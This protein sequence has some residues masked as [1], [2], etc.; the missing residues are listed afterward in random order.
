MSTDDNPTERLQ[1]VPQRS[2]SARDEEVDVSDRPFAVDVER[3]Q[4]LGTLGKGGMGE[5]L[6]AKDTR[7]ARKVAIKVLQPHLRE[8]RDFRS[9]FLIEAR[10]QGQLE[11][12]SIV[13]VHDLGEREDGEL[14]FSM[15]CVRGVTLHEALK[16]VRHGQQTT[17]FSRRR[18]LTAFSSVCL[19]IDFAHSRGVVHRDLKPAN[20]ML[21]DFGEVYV[22]DWGIAKLISSPDT[23]IEHAL[24]IP[25]SGDAATR[26]DKVLGTPHYMAPEQK[27]G[28][29]S[30]A[31]D[32]F[33]LGV[34]LR[35]LLA[36][37][38]ND[39]PPE[40]DEIMQA[41][42]APEPEARIR[43]A[44]E[45][46]DRVEKYLDG[47]RDLQLRRTQSEQHAQL[48][49]AALGRLDPSART[50]AGREIGRALGL[51]PS[52]ERAL[53]T[54]TRL[55]TEIPAT[56]PPAA[57]L[58]LDRAWQ[59]R[60]T[61]TLRLSATF[62]GTV[63]LYAPFLLWMGVRNWPLFAVWFV[64]SAGAAIMQV[65]AARNERT[66]TFL[67]A[68]V[69]ALGG[70]FVLTTSM[71]VLGYVP[72]ALTMLGVAWRVMLRRWYQGV[73]LILG[74]A[75]T[76]SAP[77]LLPLLGLMSPTYVI[78]DDVVVIHPQLH[79]FPPI[80]TMMTLVLTTIGVVAA[81]VLFG[82]VYAAEIRRAEER[83][84]FHAWQLQQLTPQANK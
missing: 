42:T 22:L 73:I 62:A 61:R 72:A 53:R 36:G 77:F 67:L 3:Y 48:A 29:A 79:H 84:T 1:M 2:E 64:L 7:I 20:I 27:H 34:I 78:H 10:L 59:A 23:P 60:R 32:V 39:V 69:C 49:E 8:R 58:E 70:A 76:I 9:R 4:P 37:D 68:F 28:V 46:H 25:H 71:G 43:T 19:A 57:Q 16:A 50:E 40:L 81:A 51:D 41:A 56:L 14:Y 24:E 52:N 63:L 66:L 54:L 47:D 5:I 74:L 33:A 38:A 6:L 65:I 31:T 18:L 45:L 75:L 17:R 80:A 13:P 30:P 55:L 26:P 12:P 83:L 15:K 11:H 35:D 82:R 21:G 44:R